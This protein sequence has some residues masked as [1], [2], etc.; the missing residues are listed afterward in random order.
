MQMNPAVKPWKCGTLLAAFW[1]FGLCR[2]KFVHLVQNPR[3][4]GDVLFRL[5]DRVYEVDGYSRTKELPNGERIQSPTFWVGGYS[6]RI[7]YYPNGARPSCADYI[8]V[9]LH[10]RRPI[11]K[12]IKVRARF[13]LLDRSGNPVPGRSSLYEEFEYLL[14]RDGHGVHEFIKRDFLEA[15]EHLVGDCFRISCDISVPAKIRTEYRAPPL[16]DLQ[17]HLGNLLV[18]KEGT[19]VT[20]QVG[21]ETFSAHRCVLAARSPVFRAELFGSTKEGTVTTKGDCIQVNDMLAHVFETLLHFIY[22]DSLPEMSGLEEPMMA[23]H[24]LKAADRYGVQRLKLICEEKLSRDGRRWAGST[25]P[26][27]PGPQINKGPQAVYCVPAPSASKQRAASTSLVKLTNISMQSEAN[28]EDDVVEK[29]AEGG[30]GGVLTSPCDGEIVAANEVG[31]DGLIVGGA[32]VGAQPHEV[33][34][35]ANYFQRS[36][37]VQQSTLQHLAQLHARSIAISSPIAGGGARR[38]SR[39]CSACGCRWLRRRTRSSPE[40]ASDEPPR[41][42]IMQRRSPLLLLSPSWPSRRPRRSFIFAVFELPFPCGG[43]DG[44]TG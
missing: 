6:W 39:R 14:L 28:C 3:L 20:F 1:A 26:T 38:R 7:F 19:D 37:L 15:S 2:S 36:A 21:G 31:D 44:E 35:A 8:S 9:F 5:C 13:S 29:I 34:G 27:D 18:A 40:D 12:P 24:L 10:L 41:R 32:A 23:E 22:T 4:H 42:H 30:G 11:A 17:Q 33:G 43:S 16:S 25:C